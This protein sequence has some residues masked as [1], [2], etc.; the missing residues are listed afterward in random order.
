M[1]GINKNGT[2]HKIGIIMP[3][4]FPASRVTYDPTTSGLTVTDVQDAIDKVYAKRVAMTV[5]PFTNITLDAQT[6]VYRYGSVFYGNII[7]TTSA[8]IAQ[9]DN[10]V[11]IENGNNDCSAT[12]VLMDRTDL[13]ATPTFLYKTASSDTFQAIKALQANHT[14]RGS[15]VF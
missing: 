6:R 3:A 5:T 8:N 15:F 1:F 12:L 14:Y 11:K 2:K 10:I 4:F 7:F 9:F 13:N